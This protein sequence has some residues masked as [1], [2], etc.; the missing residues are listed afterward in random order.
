MEHELRDAEFS[1]YG[2]FVKFFNQASQLLIDAR[3]TEPLLRNAMK[4]AKFK[5][6][7]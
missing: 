3:E 6:N 7:E 5:L 1:N 4:Y 2:E